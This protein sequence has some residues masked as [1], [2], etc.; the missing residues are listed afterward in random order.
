MLA[1][2]IIPCLDVKNG[3]TVKG[4]NFENLRDAGD[5]VALAKF[6][7]DNGADELVFLDISATNEGR[8]TMVDFAAKVAREISIPFT[9]GGGISTIE[10]MEALFRVGADKI[11]LNSSAVRD[12]EL[13]SRAADKFGC[14]AVVLAVD[15]RSIKNDE[16]R[17]TNYE[18]EEG[19]NELK[20]DY[21]VVTHGGKKGTGLDVLGWIQK[22]QALGAGEILLTSMDCDGM[23]DGFDIELLKVVKDVAQVP[24]IA[25]GGAGKMADFLEI[26]KQDLA[27]AGLAASIFHFGEVDIK[28]LKKYLAENGVCVRG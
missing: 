17:I 15:S 6:Y 1:K 22:G 26:F 25:S 7:S 9:I 14:Q 5:A 24:V 11:S 4:V 28:Q 20:I 21:E 19:A 8:K 10:D 16:L 12:P 13:I 23:K 18:K 3:R 27:D 2:R